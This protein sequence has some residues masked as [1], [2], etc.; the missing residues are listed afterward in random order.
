MSQFSR[1]SFVFSQILQKNFKISI[2]VSR[3]TSTWHNLSFLVLFI[4]LNSK[5]NRHDQHFVFD[6]LSELLANIWK[7]IKFTGVCND[8]FRILNE[9]SWERTRLCCR[10]SSQIL[11]NLS[12]VVFAV[13]QKETENIT[14]A[15]GWESWS[16]LSGLNPYVSSCTC[17][18]S[19][20]PKTPVSTAQLKSTF[21]VRNNSETL[22]PLN[23]KFSVIQPHFPQNYCNLQKPV[24][25]R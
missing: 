3:V 9:L 11:S 18:L 10:K 20:I 5:W 15:A 25:P 19:K 4:S 24:Q 6:T 8:T 1:D 21:P 7:H 23:E 22:G 17:G 16:Y 13:S 14:P 2:I 12:W